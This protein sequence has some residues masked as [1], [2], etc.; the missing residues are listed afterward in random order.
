LRSIS[1]AIYDS[2]TLLNIC[3]QDVKVG[4]SR[5]VAKSFFL[6]PAAA[7]K[8]EKKKFFGDT[9]IPG[10]DAALPAPSLL[11]KNATALR[12]YANSLV[13]RVLT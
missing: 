1:T 4:L 13:Y 8:R 3:N 2:Y 7:S 6:P 11:P 9:P 10:R 12:N 5:T